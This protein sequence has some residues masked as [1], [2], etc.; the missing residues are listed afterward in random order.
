MNNLPNVDYK[1]INQNP[2]IDS[3]YSLFELPFYKNVEYFANIDNFVQ[4]VKSVEKLVRT[5]EYYKRYIKYLKEDLGLNYCQVLSNIKSDEKE[6]IE[7]HMHHGPILSLFDCVNIVTDHMIFHEEKINTFIV[8]EEIIKEHFNNNIQVV[9]LTKTVHEEVHANNI[10][11]NLK[12]GFGDINTFLK[13]YRDGIN[14]EQITK[15]NNYID[16]SLKYDSF[17]KDTLKL[18]DTVKCWAKKKIY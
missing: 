5:S 15:I 17:D 18:Q 10:F 2:T 1:K 13:K 9:M 7:I 3:E 14:N 11:I 8:A 6:K 16:L 12:Q 4:F